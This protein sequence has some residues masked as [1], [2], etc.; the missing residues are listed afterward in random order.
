M[1]RE[2]WPGGGAGG[3]ARGAGLRGGA[4]VGTGRGGA[5]VGAGA[6]YVAFGKTASMIRSIYIYRRLSYIRTYVYMYV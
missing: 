6:G 1:D 5:G 2:A 4:G 3:G